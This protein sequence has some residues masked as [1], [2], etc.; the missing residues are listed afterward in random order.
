MISQVEL[1][2]ENRRPRYTGQKVSTTL[3]GIRS[4]VMDIR[5]D[6]I[7]VFD[8][9]RKFQQNKLLLFPDYKRYLF[10]NDEQKTRFIESIW[11]NMPL[12][13]FYVREDLRGRYILFD[14]LQRTVALFDFLEKKDFI[15]QGLQVLTELNGKSISQLDS[16]LTAA[17]EGKQLI[18]Y[19]I[20]LSVPVTMDFEIFTRINK[21]RDKRNINKRLESV[22]RMLRNE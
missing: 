7:S 18:F 10:W 11:L 13:P 16:S 21:R 6:R 22:S 4:M 1:I 14:G 12:P 2:G 19:V 20:K 15:L 5:E 17:I 9:H 3:A 8:W